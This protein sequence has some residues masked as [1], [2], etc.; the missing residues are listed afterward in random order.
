M[1][2]VRRKWGR[3]DA[4]PRTSTALEAYVPIWESENRRLF[5]LEDNVRHI[6]TLQKNNP[7]KN[8]KTTNER[9][10]CH[11]AVELGTKFRAR[12]TSSRLAQ[13]CLSIIGEIPWMNFCGYGRLTNSD[14]QLTQAMVE[15]W[16]PTTHTFHFNSFELG[17]TPLDFFMITGK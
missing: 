5:E 1:E 4:K 8:L 14:R 17:L 9:S 10:S 11:I 16:W 6:G 12:A 13:E 7:T 15:R 3:K 2:E